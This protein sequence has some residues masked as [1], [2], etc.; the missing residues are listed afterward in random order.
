MHIFCV[1]V[2]II[3]AKIVYLS[4]VSITSDNDAPSVLARVENNTERKMFFACFALLFVT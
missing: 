4:S 1:V 2:K 3:A